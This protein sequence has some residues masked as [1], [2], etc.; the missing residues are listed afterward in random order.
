MCIRD[1]GLRVLAFATKEFTES[2][3]SSLGEKLLKDRD[4]VESSLIFQGLIGI[5]DPPRPETAGAVKKCHRAGVNVHMLTGDFPGTAKAIAQEVGIL[6]HNLYHYPKEVVNTMVM[7]A[8]HF[9]GLTDE[10][11]DDLPVL[12]LV[13]DV[14]KR[15]VLWVVLRGGLRHT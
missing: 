9:D 8:S 2:E 6:P 15:Q 4:F 1:R 12:P 10:Q 7:T 14:Y 5:Y 11:I 13:I 3:A